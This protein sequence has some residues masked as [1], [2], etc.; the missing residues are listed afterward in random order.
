MGFE[1]SDGLDIVML[2]V[3][4]GIQFVIQFEQIV[5]IDDFVDGFD[6]FDLMVLCVVQGKDDG[7]IYGV[8]FVYQIMQMFYN[9][10][11]FDEM[12]F[13]EF[14]DWD[15]F[16]ELQEILF[17]EGV[18]LMVF[19]VCEDWVLLMFYDIVG[20]VNYGGFEFEEKVFV[21]DV[22]F[23]DFVY[24]FLLQ[25]VKDMQ[26]Y[27]DK[28]VNVIVVVDVV[29]QFIL[30]QVVQWFGGFFDLLMFQNFVLDIEWGVY[31][32]LL[33]FG[34][35]FDYVVIFGYVDGSFGINVVSE[36]Q[37]VVI[38]LFNWMIMKEFGQF[39][40][41]EV[42]QFLVLFGVEYFDLLMQEMNEQYIVNLVLYLLFVDFCYG[43]LIGM[44]VF[45]LDIQVMF[46]GDKI[47]EQFG[48]DLQFGIFIWFIF[49]F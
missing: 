22:D 9:K 25:I 3:Y 11:M 34:S 23:I 42:D 37:E 17:G 4:G 39:V 14:M 21:G 28:N 18:I 26:K 5:L 33:V 43:D 13:E 41:D 24:V 12:G 7:K 20:L 31:E 2:C 44:V 8:F 36:K 40:V 29:L 46:F 6:Q 15:E 16:I 48:V 45:G 27:F 47:F 38:E 30:G 32:V 49:V 35:V 19:G 1:G 10:I